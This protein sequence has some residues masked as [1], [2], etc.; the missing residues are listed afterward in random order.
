LSAS[1]QNIPCRA[2]KVQGKRCRGVK[3]SLHGT[4]TCLFNQSNLFFC[5][6]PLPGKVFAERPGFT[7]HS[8]FEQRD[9]EQLWRPSFS[10]T[11]PPPTSMMVL[12]SATAP[13]A[14][15]PRRTR[16]GPGW[17]RSTQRLGRAPAPSV[18]RFD[19][20]MRREFVRECGLRMKSR[21]APGGS[22]A[23]LYRLRVRCAR[24]VEPLLL[25]EAAR[26]RTA[27]THRPLA[28]G[29][30][31]AG[32]LKRRPSTP[33]LACFFLPFLEIKLPC[34]PAASPICCSFWRAGIARNKI[35][36]RLL[37][38]FPLYAT[39]PRTGP[40]ARHRRPAETQRK[41]RA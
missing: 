2:P 28:P 14:Q 12:P 20:E 36:A 27:R 37:Q 15:R 22:R 34:T 24:S 8:P 39:E 1:A 6:S 3:E 30:F 33:D 16:A 18:D 41:P 32:H 13:W 40:W 23:M 26:P 25:C 21:F 17:P 7:S 11:P 10:R 29:F 5:P 9:S 31:G 38:V 4:W 35:G 19:H